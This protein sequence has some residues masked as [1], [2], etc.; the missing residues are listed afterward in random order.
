MKIS[1]VIIVKDGA[2]T[3]KRTLDSLESFN[4]IIV[5][6]NGSTDKTL[7]IVESY[8]NVNLI[9]GD[10]FGFGPTKNKA[11]SYAKNDWILILDSD[12][13]IDID[14]D[15]DIDIDT[16]VAHNRDIDKDIDIDSAD[17]L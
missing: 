2:K 5:Y 10:F 1:V 14:I 4:D 7:D 6:D 16:D 17:C 12:E 13:V 8:K 15:V 11:A 3:I 9:K